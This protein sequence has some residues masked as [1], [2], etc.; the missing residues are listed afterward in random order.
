MSSYYARC[1]YR[2][3]FEVIPSNIELLQINLSFFEECYCFIDQ[4]CMCLPCAVL[5]F[6]QAP[7]LLSW[8]SAL[9]INSSRS[10]MT[11]APPL[12]A[13]VCN[14]Y[15]VFLCQILLSL[16]V[17]VLLHYSNVL[18]YCCFAILVLQSL[19]KYSGQILE[20]V[21]KGK[22]WNFL[23]QLSKLSFLV[24]DWPLAS[25]SKY[26]R[27]FLEYFKYYKMLLFESC[28]NFRQLAHSLSGNIKLIPFHFC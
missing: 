10:L 27:D 12:S 26:Y 1:F 5:S 19:T 20:L 11:I 9:F 4:P 16:F 22:F 14:N 18:H 21:K 25:I 2:I 17:F 13:F 24:S 6:V 28:D 15:I 23:E 7:L 8:C 3:D